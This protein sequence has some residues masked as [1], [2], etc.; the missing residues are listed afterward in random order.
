MAAALAAVVAAG[1]TI[2]RG[3]GRLGIM[4]VL[5]AMTA[6]L[7]LCPRVHQLVWKQKVN[8]LGCIIVTTMEGFWYTVV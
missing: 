5:Q 8:K 2:R 6:E 7:S 4:V 1:T 3:E